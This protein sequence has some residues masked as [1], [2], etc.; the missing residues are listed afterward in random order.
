[1]KS[2]KRTTL[3]VLAAMLMAAVAPITASAVPEAG[4]LQLQ[5]FSDQRTAAA[6]GRASVHVLFHNTSNAALEA[7]ELSLLTAGG[8]RFADA[9]V[10]S[11]LDAQGKGSVW[12]VERIEAGEAGS[13]TLVADVAADASGSVEIGCQAVSAGIQVGFGSET[14]LT[15][16]TEV[17][18][19]V[20]NGYPDGTFRPEGVM[21]RAET[22]AVIARELNLSSAHQGETRF[23]DVE[24]GHWA[25][26][27]IESVSEAGYMI[28]DA[29]RFRP[30][31]SITYAEWITILL[32]MKAVHAVPL[33]V[34]LPNGAGHWAADSIR[35]AVG[36]GYTDIP[37]APD[38]SVP[39]ET[40]AKLFAISLYRGELTD[41]EEQV[42]QHWPDVPR[43]SPWFGWIEELSMKAHESEQQG[44][45]KERLIEYRPEE[46]EPF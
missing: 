18:Q 23:H 13:L 38:G 16:G 24:Q 1:M 46:T 37:D 22:A 26:G 14:T 17:H 35:T 27:Y 9:P 34:S 6:G 5:C 43:T 33:D 11:L 30:E 29:E 2:N 3:V 25:S 20:F 42:V 44:L 45:L 4:D 41:G 36:L 39:R 7:V 28:G 12:T 10:H 15:I 21:T 8:L 19:P 31:E 40:A 32:R